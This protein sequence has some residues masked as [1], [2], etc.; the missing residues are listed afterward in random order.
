M[1]RRSDSLWLGRDSVPLVTSKLQ[2]ACA[3]ASER[4]VNI[5][6][7][8]STKSRVFG[9]SYKIVVCVREREGLPTHLTVPTFSRLMPLA[10]NQ[11]LPYLPTHR[12][13]LQNRSAVPLHH[14]VVLWDG[15]GGDKLAAHQARLAGSPEVVISP[16]RVDALAGSVSFG[17]LLLQ[18][19]HSQLN[20]KT[21]C[22]SPIW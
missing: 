15:L 14:L 18:L 5:T 8:T 12:A 2:Q 17:T 9:I 20:R 13:T 11:S 1:T 16:A 6:S 10:S 7:I 4:A 19:F 3:V 22:T 21:T